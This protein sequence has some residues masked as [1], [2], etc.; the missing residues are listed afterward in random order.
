VAFAGDEELD[1][2]PRPGPDPLEADSWGEAPVDQTSVV[3][4]GRHHTPTSSSGLRLT[5]AA[6]VAALVAIVTVAM[7]L[8]GTPP[9]VPP[10]AAIDPDLGVGLPPQSSSQGSAGV[11]TSPTGPTATAVVTP[12]PTSRGPVAT[13]K[14][15]AQAPPGKP[16][17]PVSVEAEAGLPKV[18]LSGSAWI[19]GYPA[20]SN[21]KVVRNLGD[22][23]MRG[24]PGSLRF[25]D[26]IFPTTG[27]YV[28]TISYVHQDNESTRTAQVS[29][30]GVN[31]VTVTFQGSSTCC[32]TKKVSLVIPA[33]TRTITISNARGRAPAVDKIVI[34][35]T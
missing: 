14:P 13:G 8:A 1:R 24:G 22:W 10:A 11:S 15:T 12:V 17:T 25:N 7:L 35:T 16:F 19:D 32:S 3:Y 26:V 2:Q 4:S 23:D 5:I 34:G 31:A 33:G 20:A 28:L 18:T 21:G 6:G 27:T 30:S 29:V 9:P